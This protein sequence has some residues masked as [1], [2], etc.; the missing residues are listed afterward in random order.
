MDIFLSSSLYYESA[1]NSR[2]SFVQFFSFFN[3]CAI[4]TRKVMPIKKD[5]LDK[6]FNKKLF[7][8]T[9]SGWV[10]CHIVKITLRLFWVNLTFEW[11]LRWFMRKRKCWIKFYWWILKDFCLK[12]EKVLGRCGE[13][14]KKFCSEFIP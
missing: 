6:Y 7:Y 4:S 9:F 1:N 8:L 11:I 5:Y 3:F 12:G 2:K 13:K 14:N 10:M